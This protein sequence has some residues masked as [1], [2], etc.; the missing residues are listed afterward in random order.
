MAKVCVYVVFV[1]LNLSFNSIHWLILLISFVFCTTFCSLFAFVSLPW[2]S[3]HTAKCLHC[4]SIFIRYQH[5]IGS[6]WPHTLYTYLCGQWL[7]QNWPISLHDK[8]S[9]GPCDARESP[10]LEITVKWSIPSLRSHGFA[11]F[12]GFSHTQCDTND[13]CVSGFPLTAHGTCKRTHIPRKCSKLIQLHPEIYRKFSN[14]NEITVILGDGERSDR[15]A[16]GP[17]QCDAR[18]IYCMS[19]YPIPSISSTMHSRTPP[20]RIDGDEIANREKS[21]QKQQ[22]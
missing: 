9:A 22:W 2:H 10:T 20:S 13:C 8:Y 15:Q 12:Y 5:T 18:P 1:L 16:T 17:G 3:T 11:G 7:C 6:Y 14:W 19:L 21:A 4:Q